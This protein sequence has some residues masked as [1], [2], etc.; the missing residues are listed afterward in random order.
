LFQ[1]FRET[2]KAFLGWEC[3]F[4]C[5]KIEK[6]KEI[7]HRFTHISTKGPRNRPI[8]III[9]GFKSHLLHEIKKGENTAILRK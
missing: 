8:W 2:E 3:F 1:V 9:E 4:I 6:A 5:D 7:T